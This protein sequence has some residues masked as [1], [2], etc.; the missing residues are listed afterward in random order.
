M[1]NVCMASRIWAVSVCAMVLASHGQAEVDVWISSL[2]MRDCLASKPAIALK[3]DRGGKADDIIVDLTKTRQSIL[4]IG[5]SLEHSTCYNLSQLDPA[6]RGEAIERLL[7]PDKGIGM[8]LM[9]LCIGTSDFTGDPWYS[10]DDLPEGQTDP[11]LERFSIAKDHDYLLPIIKA[12]QAANPDLLFFASPWS[13]PAWMKDSGNLCGGRLLPQHH[14]AY[15]RYLARFIKAYEAEGIPIHAITIQNEPGVNVTTYPSCAWTGDVQRD[16]I[17][18]SLGPLFASEGIKALVWC[19]D[20]NFNN[21]AFPQAILRDPDA[22]KFVDG[23]AFHLYEG[24]PEAM[25]ALAREFPDKHVYFTEGSTYNLGG[26]IQIMNYFAN[27]ARSYNAWVTVIDKKGKPNNGPHHCSPTCIVFDP[28]A[29]TLA[30]RFDYYMYGHFSKFV[31]RGARVIETV[32]G[33]PRFNHI[34][35][36]NPD[37]TAVLVAAN[38]TREKRKFGVRCQGQ[39]FQAELPPQSMATYSWIA[40]R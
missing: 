21:V 24:K 2:D 11:N 3:K 29:K 22:A 5:S 23:T 16:F 28:V 10:Y 20:H 36:L 31:K 1:K 39:A 18:N 25:G 6:R 19:F 35:F 40:S 4:G 8:N 27:G 38:N 17:K 33:D 30:Y 9:R 7:D 32:R 12:A 15:A 13:P 26:A 14:D 34:A 37:G